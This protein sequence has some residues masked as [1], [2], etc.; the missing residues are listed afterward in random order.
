MFA[1]TFLRYS[2]T[3]GEVLAQ[4]TDACVVGAHKIRGFWAAA[5]FAHWIKWP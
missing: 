3:A 1:T 5:H 2:E 4:G